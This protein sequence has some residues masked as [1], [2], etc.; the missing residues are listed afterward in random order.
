MLVKT[1]YLNI[2]E[3]LNSDY[4]KTASAKGLAKS[5]VTIKHA[6]RNA[7]LP[8]ITDMGQ[9]A[10]SVVIGRLVVETFLVSLD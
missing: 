8:G 5:A 1:L 3:V 9:M 10:T 7:M 4:I 2:S 6:I